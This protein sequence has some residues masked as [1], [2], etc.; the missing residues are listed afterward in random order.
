MLISKRYALVINLVNTAIDHKL[1]C[2]GRDCNVSL[3]M[4]K[5]A[6]IHITGDIKEEKELLSAL[7][8]IKETNWY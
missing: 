2:Q 1:L 4:L 3:G 5:E 7:E 6:A 8:L